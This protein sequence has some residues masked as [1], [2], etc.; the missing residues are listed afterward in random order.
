M[1]KGKNKQIFT[2][3]QYM[4][5]GAIRVKHTQRC[6]TRVDKCLIIYALINTKACLY[7]MSI[8][9]K[10][11]TLRYLPFIFCMNISTML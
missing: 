1:W 10:H 11:V 6:S 5:N 9:I 3:N 2:H 4:N 7:H 8:H